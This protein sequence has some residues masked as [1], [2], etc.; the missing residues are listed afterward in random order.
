MNYFS[1]LPVGL[2]ISVTVVFLA[3]AVVVGI[4]GR[5]S[6]VLGAATL[7]LL[8][9]GAWRLS[10][11]R[12]LM[13]LLIMVPLLIG[14]LLARLDWH[15]P[16]VGRYSA[17]L[18]SVVAVLLF[19]DAVRIEEWIEVIRKNSRRFRFHD[20][21]AIVIGTAVGIISLSLSIQ[22]QRALRKLAGT[23][24]WR[25]KSQ[26]SV[27]FDSLAFPFY[28]AVESH[29]FIDEALRRW[30]SRQLEKEGRT[31]VESAEVKSLA[32]LRFGNSIFAAR[33]IDIYSFPYFADVV[34]AL[35][36]PPSVPEPWE[37]ALAGL[38]KG[39]TALDINGRTGQLA[40][41]LL[42]AGL[43]VTVFEQ[44]RP[45]HDELYRIQ[46]DY[47]SCVN[48]LT[49][50]LFGSS[51][52]RFDCIFFHD[53]AFL[54]MT[55]EVETGDLLKGLAGLC[56]PASRI[57]FIYPEF[58]TLTKNGIIF[59]GT[60]PGIGH[61][62]YQYT[63]YERAHELASTLVSYTVTKGHDS[64]CV[65]TPLTFRA[66][67]LPNILLAAEQAGFTHKTST[68][69]QTV[70]LFPGDKVFVELCRR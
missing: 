25:T 61:V 42:Q 20:V 23:Y 38:G 66:P 50:S 28:T 3:A 17:G 48:I 46:Q 21:S 12:V 37:Q 64:Y 54:E 26:I 18:F 59:T 5:P 30:G 60:I 34:R 40:H 47:G 70:S 33:L 13:L 41:R 36:T 39:S 31:A 2:R 19:M 45:F 27:F 16:F 53:N 58:E 63:E 32:D 29:E 7:I 35:S 43:M 10:R 68:I 57:F 6:A 62:D 49:A 9:S 24:R 14:L 44:M 51:L 52:G 1:K 69:R 55:N 15:H 8:V 56:K 22:E 65:R 11:L 4:V 67:D